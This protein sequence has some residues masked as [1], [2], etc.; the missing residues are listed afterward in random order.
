MLIKK[1]IWQK[2]SENIIEQCSQL[3]N[4]CNEA[5]G[6][7]SSFF[8]DNEQPPFLENVLPTLF[9]A[10]NDFNELMGFLSVYIY[11]EYECEVCLFVHPEYIRRK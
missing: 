7:K 11:D 1:L 6:F 4:V 2:I 5:D 3:A 10:Y 8:I 9:L